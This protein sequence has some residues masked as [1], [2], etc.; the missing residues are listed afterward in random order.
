MV[1]VSAEVE[2]RETREERGFMK[3][4][5]KVSETGSY[6]D[7]S[8]MLKVSTL[9]VCTRGWGGHTV[10]EKTAGVDIGY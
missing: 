10:R 9:M 3:Q 7:K 2:G 5:E 1:A 8:R 4:Q 6:V